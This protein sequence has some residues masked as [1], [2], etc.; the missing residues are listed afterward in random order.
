MGGTRGPVGRITAELPAE[1]LR[2]LVQDFE[3]FLRRAMP[4][5]WDSTQR[6]FDYLATGPMQVHLRGALSGQDGAVDVE[7]AFSDRSGAAVVSAELGSHWVSFWLGRESK[8]LGAAGFNPPAARPQAPAFVP[9]EG[10]SYGLR[11]SGRFEFDAAE[12]VDPRVLVRI[13]VK[14]AHLGA[15]GCLCQLCRQDFTPPD[16]GA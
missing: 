14:Y 2:A 4:H 9:F 16:P 15:D 11:E 10:L 7:F 13:A 5:P 1:D 6:F 12:G 3:R 8:R